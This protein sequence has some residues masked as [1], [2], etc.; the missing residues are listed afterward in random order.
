MREFNYSALVQRL[1][2]TEILNYTNLIH[3]YKGKQDLYNSINKRVLFM[4]NWQQN[5]SV[6]LRVAKY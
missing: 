3:E 1:W 5:G 6:L 4:K 2:N